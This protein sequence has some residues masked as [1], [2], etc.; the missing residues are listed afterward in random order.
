MNRKHFFNLIV[1]TCAT[2]ILRLVFVAP[3]YAAGGAPEMWPVENFYAYDTALPFNA[4]EKPDRETGGYTVYHLEFDSRHGKRVYAYYSLPKNAVGPYP[5]VLMM[6]GYGGSRNM[7]FQGVEQLSARGYAAMALDA[8]YHGDRKTPGKNMYSKLAYSSRDAMIQTVID[9][10]RGIDYMARREDIDADR[11]GYIGGS[12]GGIIGAALAA[13]EPRLRATALAV[14]GADWGYLLEHSVVAQA[15][16]LNTGEHPLD[17]GHFRRVVTPAD[18]INLAHLISPRPV[19]MLNA[20]HDVLVNPGSNRLLFNRLKEPR[21]II[22]FDEGHDIGFD[23]A[24]P[25]IEEFFDDY[26]VGDKDPAELGT[27]VTGHETKPMKTL[28]GRELPPPR[29]SVPLRY[30]FEY[31]SFLPLVP[32]DAGAVEFEDGEAEFVFLS[33]HDKR[34]PGHAEIP[35]GGDAPRGVLVYVHEVG[36]S[37]REAP[38]LARLAVENGYMFIAFDLEYHGG[39][40]AGGLEFFSSLPVI[41]ADAMLQTTFDIRRA[42]DFALAELLPAAGAQHAGGESPDIVVASRGIASSLLAGMAAALDPRIDDVLFLE[43]AMNMDSMAKMQKL[44]ESEAGQRFYELSLW[45]EYL[46]EKQI[47]E[48]EKIYVIK[49]VSYGLQMQYDGL[50]IVRFDDEKDFFSARK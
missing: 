6:S 4:S 37:R 23:N 33:T 38:E 17:A 45:T 24:Y 19:L 44:K 29:T 1:F 20:K 46:R 15:L 12:M 8:E 30:L 49:G 14:G 9:Y 18:P 25:Y 13:V 22:W 50:D 48:R 5:L 10:M 36:G 7:L 16:G 41:T 39:R 47:R 32:E 26:L 2:A 3:L 40:A 11:I 35:G 42:I 34:A 43:G 27:Q 21:K 31:E 28:F